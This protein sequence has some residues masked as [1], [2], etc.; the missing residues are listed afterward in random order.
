[1]L[2]TGSET[3][4]FVSCWEL[5]WL[6][7]CQRHCTALKHTDFK[8][9]VLIFTQRRTYTG[10]KRQ[11]SYF[12][13]YIYTRKRVL[14]LADGTKWAGHSCSEKRRQQYKNARAPPSGHT[15][16][17]QKSES[18]SFIFHV[19]GI[20]YFLHGFIRRLTFEDLI[21][22]QYISAFQTHDTS[23]SKTLTH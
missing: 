22:K 4:T 9:R 6:L 10:S 18:G 11:G 12:E 21:C 7:S 14:W 23:L 1:M 16:S 8:I 20:L 15:I 2:Q 13:K 3:V 17:L 5:P 19:V